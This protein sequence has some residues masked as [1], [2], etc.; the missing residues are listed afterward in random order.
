MLLFSSN[1][2]DVALSEEFAEHYLSLLAKEKSQSGQRP[3]SSLVFP[4][5][6]CGF[7]VQFAVHYLSLLAKDN[8]KV[9]KD[10]SSLFFPVPNS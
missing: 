4:F 6:S 3:M 9:E 2:L 7:F 1:Y 10:M 8:H 5:F